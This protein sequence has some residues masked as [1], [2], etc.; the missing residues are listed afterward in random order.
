MSNNVVLPWVS[1]LTMQQQ[2]VLLLALRDHDGNVKETPVKRIL[3][4]YRPSI[5]KA[6]KYG[7]ELYPGEQGD[8]FMSLR[9][10]VAGW[11]WDHILQDFAEWYDSANVHYL[12]HLIYGAEVLGY[13]HPNAIL[14]AR[15]HKFYTFCITECM[16]FHIESEAEMDA[17]LCDWGKE[18]WDTP[19]V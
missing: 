4:A 11:T 18:F 9:E 5:I 13:K 3:R 6:A 12:R 8:R 16:H 10:I 19:E 7:R 1:A 15:W 17:R 14:R 2:S